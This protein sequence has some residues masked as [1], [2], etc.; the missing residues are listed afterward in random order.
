MRGP[1]GAFVLVCLQLLAGTFVFM[2][3]AHLRWKFINRGYYR[4]TTWVLWPLTAVLTPLLPSSLRL[5]NLATAVAMLV[6]LGAVYSQR[7]LLEW[8]TGAVASAGSLWLIILAG[9][10]GCIRGCGTEVT[11]AVAGL[12]LMGA[13]TH[14]MVLGHWYLNQA[15]LPIEP[16]A[17]HT[18]VL[19]LGIAVS[20]VIGVA[21]R[22]QVTDGMVPG[23]IFAFSGSSYWWVWLLLLG[24]TAGLG[25]MIMATVKERA[26]QSATGLLYIAIVT[27]LGAQFVL[28]LLILS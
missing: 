8:V 28:N 17:Q 21:T 2:W 12:V 25:A 1:G 3:M 22:G 10:A 26:T 27:A 11:H 13:V 20:G 6:F 9:L 19:F 18:W 7:P 14:A 5:L 16:L 4:S 15:R 24:A 23:G